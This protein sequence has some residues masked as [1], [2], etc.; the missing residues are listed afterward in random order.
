MIFNLIELSEE[1][2]EWMNVPETYWRNMTGFKM[3]KEFASK[4]SVTNDS[5]ERN[6][7]LIQE[8]VNSCHDEPL[9]QDLLLALDST[10]RKAGRPKTSKKKKRKM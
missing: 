7:K 9:R 5:A 2:R 6:V 3:F 10:K 8:F 1:Q 4:L